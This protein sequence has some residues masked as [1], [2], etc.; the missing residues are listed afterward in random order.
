LMREG[1]RVLAVPLGP[2]Q[3]RYDVGHEKGYRE[4]ARDFSDREGGDA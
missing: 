4:A 1:R 2:G 3:V